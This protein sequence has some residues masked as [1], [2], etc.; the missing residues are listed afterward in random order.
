MADLETS[1]PAPTGHS[2]RTGTETVP[3]DTERL[4]AYLAGVGLPLD[5]DQPIRQFASGLANI[6]YLIHAGGQPLVLRRPPS[7]ELPPGAHDMAREH[8]VLSRLGDSFP[9][10]PRSLH[11]CQ[12]TTVIGVPFQLIAYREGTVVKGDDRTRLGDPAVCRRL[13]L[14]LVATLADLHAVDPASVGLDDFG[15]PEGFTRRQIA[16]WKG[17]AE[18]IADAGTK[19]L[20]DE[21]V[22]WLERQPIAKR[23]PVLLH[24]DLKLDNMILTADTLAPV[25]VVD[26]DQSTRGDP[27]FDLAT[28]LSYWTQA[29]DP[30]VMHRMAQM[31]TAA[32]GFPSRAEAVAHYARLTGI[33]VSD[34]PLYR[35]LAML[36][37]A[38]VFQQLHQLWVRGETRDPR[39]AG[40]GGLARDLLELT[41]EI[42]RGRI[43]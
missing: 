3:I 32:S 2:F 4:A 33:D 31:P 37:L 43:S 40:F 17:R 7:G 23:T 14:T 35:V 19:A 1:A 6:N 24:S 16:G 15:K 18:R 34:M 29:G 5:P 10:A 9:L 25:A 38:V 28:T 22:A 21:I 20:T 30:E 39:Y 12:D 8:R 41:R 13:G 42:M 27:L 36:K 26:W 11:L